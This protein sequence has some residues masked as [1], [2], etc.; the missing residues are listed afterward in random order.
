[1]FWCSG[2]SVSK[3]T[4]NDTWPVSLASLSQIISE[5]DDVLRTG[6]LSQRILSP[7]YVLVDWLLFCLKKRG[8]LFLPLCLSALNPQRTSY[9]VFFWPLVQN[10]SSVAVCALSW[11]RLKIGYEEHDVLFWPFCQ[12]YYS[13][14]ACSVFWLLWLK[15]WIHRLDVLFLR[16]LCLKIWRVHFM[17]CL[18]GSKYG[19]GKHMF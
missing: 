12:K 16:L 19:Y 10:N 8:L 6:R 4:F 5:I 14:R 9:V 7:L 11:P 1:M 18:S 2:F 17:V 15:T 13:R 3:F